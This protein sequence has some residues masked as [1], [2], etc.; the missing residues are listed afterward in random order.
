[1]VPGMAMLSDLNVVILSNITSSIS[2]VQSAGNAS[3]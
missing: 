3:V 1:M 2:S